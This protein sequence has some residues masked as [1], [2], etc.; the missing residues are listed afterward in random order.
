[1]KFNF[2]DAIIALGLVICG[3]S[4]GAIIWN[5]ISGNVFLMAV[6]M[7]VLCCAAFIVAGIVGGN[8]ND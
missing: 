6:W 1:M 7:V 4:F 8:C 3:I 5:V 2:I